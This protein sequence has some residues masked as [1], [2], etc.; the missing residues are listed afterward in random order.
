MRSQHDSL[1]EFAARIHGTHSPRESVTLY[2]GLLSFAAR[3]CYSS[4][5]HAFVTR[6]H[7]MNSLNKF[8]ARIC[9][10][11]LLHEFVSRIHFTDSLRAFLLLLI[12][13]TN[14]PSEIIMRSW[15]QWDYYCTYHGR[16][17]T[18]DTGGARASLV[19]WYWGLRSFICGMVA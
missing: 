3:T 7:G 6:I 4:S 11:N 9:R 8:A 12:L 1:R 19:V 17:Q 5:P 2:Y 13:R 10:A 14:L 18:A 16:S 15:L